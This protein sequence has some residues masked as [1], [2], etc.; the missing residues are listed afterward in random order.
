[1]FQEHCATTCI[2]NITSRLLLRGHDA[3]K[4]V[5]ALLYAA[6]CYVHGGTGHKARVPFVTEPSV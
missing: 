4:R 6:H 3:I 5:T 2:F 1:M